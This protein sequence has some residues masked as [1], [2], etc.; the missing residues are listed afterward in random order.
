MEEGIMRKG[1]LVTVALLAFVVGGIFIGCAKNDNP[2]TP[3]IQGDKTVTSIE[4]RVTH[5]L[6]NGL[7]GENRTEQITAIARNAAGVGVQG[8][9]ILFGIQ[10]PQTHKGTISVAAA[11]TATDENGQTIANYTVVLD[12]DADV[13]IFAQAG[14]VSAQKTIQLRV[15]DGGTGSLSLFVERQVLTVPPNQVKSTMVTATLVGD[16]GLAIPGV[17]VNF[18]T[19]PATFGFVDSDT[20]ITDN[21]GRVTRTF[22]S[23]VNRY[24]SCEVVA[25]VGTVEQRATVEIREVAGPEYISLT[26]SPPEIKIAEGENG[27]AQIQAVVTD[28]D[29]VGVPDIRVLFKLESYEGN[30]IFGSLTS[31]DTTT[32]DDGEIYTTFNTRGGFGTQYIV[33]SVVP[34]VESGSTTSLGRELPKDLKLDLGNGV[35]AD[36]DEDA[37]VARITMTVT[38]LEDAPR[39]MDISATPNFFSIP[40]DSTGRS[41][42]E[43]VV[44]DENRNGIPNLAVNFGTNLGTLSQPTATDSSG[45]ARINFFIRPSVDLPADQSGDAIA[46]ITAKIPGTNWT[47][48]IDI[49]IRPQAS[50]EGKLIIATDRRF[51]WADGT[52]LSYATLTA[53]LQDADGQILSGKEI[54]FTSSFPSSVVQSPIVTDSV[55]RA[56]T[57]FDDAG[58]PSTDANGMPDSVLVTAKYEPMGLNATLRILIAERNPVTHINLNAL[59]RVMMASSGDSTSIRATCLLNDGSPA[60]AGTQVSFSAI[61][62]SFTE[63]VV[64]IAGNAGAAETRY[65]A[66]NQVGVD[67]L[68]AFVMTPTDTAYSNEVIIDLISGPPSQIQVSVNPRE[69]MTNDPTATALCTAMVMDTVGS[70]VRQGTPVNFTITLGSITPSAITDENGN[71]VAQ[72]R[73]GVEA[74]L[75]IIT[76]TANGQSGQVTGTTTITFVS[77]TP[78]SITLTADPL[79]VAVQGTGGNTT[80]TLRAVVRDANGNLVERPVTVKFELINEPAWRQGSRIGPDTSFYYSQT[81]QGIAL[82]TFNSGEQIGGKL[83]RATTWADSGSDRQREVS[84]ILS[85]VAVVSG[86]PMW[87]SIDVNDDGT[88]AGGGSWA[89]EVSARV[90]DIHNNPVANDIP[91][92]FGVHPDIANIDPGSTGNVGAAG[93]SIPGLA[94]SYMIYNSQNTFESIEITA[95]VRTL[96]G[97]I[98]GSRPHVLALQEGNLEL[99]VDPGNWMFN[100]NNPHAIIRCWV[101]LTDGHQ[102]LINNG[103]ILFTSNRSRFSWYNFDSNEY[104]Q[105]FPDPV[106]K[107]TGIEDRENT[108]RPG[109][110]TVFLEAEMDDI[111]LDPFTLEVTVQIN[112]QVEGYN[113]VTADPGFIFFTRLAR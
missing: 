43:A 32:N 20:G 53:I 35:I 78:N 59:A 27:Q 103:P 67:T 11:D 22:T 109:Q 46:T 66:G 110:T 24:G 47:A 36:V 3:I 100:E 88:D 83:I 21:S 62:G 34:S 9:K 102:I 76:A 31:I 26:A 69:L 63:A 44:R 74:G 104:V 13:V 7:V 75:A 99:N 70:R 79:Q 17:Q 41:L 71:A 45:V 61:L 90:Y 10:D 29:G 2:S 19:S 42:I 16:D 81:S 89:V 93:V 40:S 52:G 33:A 101:V 8:V 80:S 38:P 25:K 64:P 86:P 95:E 92:V 23:I 112:A 87:L 68:Q 6:I 65:I 54:K 98:T 108:E 30:P 48:A 77:G 58:I 96:A 39:S 105:F 84:V 15:R 107:L 94:Y 4:M 28:L 37:L 57:V 85:R 82:A 111:F 60:P 72:V 18:S 50:N 113:D 49:T 91:V 56:I 12:R 97:Q 14:Q 73:P 106:R 5:S 1:F 55:G 51:I